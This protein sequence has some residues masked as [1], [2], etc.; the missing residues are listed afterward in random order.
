MHYAVDKAVRS[1]A[2]LSI[3]TGDCSDLSIIRKLRCKCNALSLKDGE[4]HLS[5][6]SFALR[7]QRPRL[8]PSVHTTPVQREDSQAKWR[9]KQIYLFLL[10]I[11]GVYKVPSDWAWLALQFGCIYTAQSYRTH[12]IYYSHQIQDTTMIQNV[13]YFTLPFSVPLLIK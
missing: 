5:R 4:D 13:Y 10:F 7:T 2:W 9:N 3:W 11:I 6:D 1:K 12:N 8:S